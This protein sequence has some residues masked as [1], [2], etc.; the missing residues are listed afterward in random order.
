MF[1]HVSFALTRI[2]SKIK[3]KT[4]KMAKIWFWPC[5]FLVPMLGS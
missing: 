1:E 3:A 4:I 5:Q 2:S